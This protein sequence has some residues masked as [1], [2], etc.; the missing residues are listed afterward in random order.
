MDIIVGSLTDV[1][2]TGIQPAILSNFGPEQGDSNYYQYRA[3]SARNYGKHRGDEVSNEVVHASAADFRTLINRPTTEGV[4]RLSPRH[5]I[6]FLL[7][8]RLR[9]PCDVDLGLGP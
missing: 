1:R 7:A 5:P 8:L 9:L 4:A 6:I 3:D 2:S